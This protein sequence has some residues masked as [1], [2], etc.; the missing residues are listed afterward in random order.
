MTA[1]LEIRV[2]LGK[3]K[4][5]RKAC[6]MTQTEVGAIIGCTTGGYYREERADE[7]LSV[8]SKLRFLLMNLG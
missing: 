2:D 7:D 1:N 4:Q 8:L 3:I 6:K 5:L